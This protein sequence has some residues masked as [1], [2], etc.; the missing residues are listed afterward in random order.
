MQLYDF[1]IVR[2]DYNVD[3]WSI[4]FKSNAFTKLNYKYGDNVVIEIKKPHKS[5][6]L[7]QLRT[8]HPLINAFY[9]TGCHSA[10]DWV[11]GPTAFKFWLKSSFGAHNEY[12][13]NGKLIRDPK[14]F[15]D[16]T[17]EELAKF[18]DDLKSYIEQSGAVAESYELQEILKGMELGS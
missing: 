4:Q 2:D 18:I 9:F 6:T 3:C 10:P 11:K 5:K 15:A 8:V 1:K 14:S 12:E 7:Q 17:I 16:Y 13:K